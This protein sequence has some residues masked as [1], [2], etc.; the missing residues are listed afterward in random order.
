M[1]LATKVQVLRLMICMWSGGVSVAALVSCYYLVIV[2]AVIVLGR[3]DLV[4]ELTIT[5]NCQVPLN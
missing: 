5:V 4:F 1:A 3:H 2:A